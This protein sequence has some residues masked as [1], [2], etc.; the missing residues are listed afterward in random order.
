MAGR[1]GEPTDFR[2]VP[3]PEGD[4][5]MSDYAA[6]ER[7]ADLLRRVEEHGHP[8]LLPTYH[9]LG[10]QYGVTASVI[11]RDLDKIAASVEAHADQ[12]TTLTVNSVYRRA[13]RGLVENEDWRAAAKTATEWS[14][15]VDRR[16][17]LRDLRDRLDALAE[18]RDAPLAPSSADPDPTLPEIVPT[19]D[20]ALAVRDSDDA[21]ADAPTPEG[22][23]E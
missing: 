14:E 10:E 18:D 16:T 23:P 17:V 2:N 7:R 1:N 8:S 19:D 5:P 6:D 12:R 15:W 21:D 3:L 9:E 11:C 20:G 22:G 4:R 13:L